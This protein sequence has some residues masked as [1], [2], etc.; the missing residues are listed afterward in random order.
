MH[1]KTGKIHDKGYTKFNG[2]GY[3]GYNYF[4]M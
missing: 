3:E 1:T 4:V 2:Y